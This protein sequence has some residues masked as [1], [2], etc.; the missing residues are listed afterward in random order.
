MCFCEQALLSIRG[1]LKKIAVIAVASGSLLAPSVVTQQPDRN[2]IKEF[3]KC[4]LDEHLMCVAFSP[5]DNQLAIG[6][7]KGSLWLWSI[8][9][10]EK[11]RLFMSSGGKESTGAILCVAFSPDGK[12]ILFGADNQVRLWDIGTKKE[13]FCLEGHGGPVRSVAFRGD[14]RQALSGSTS[15][16]TI[17]EWNLETGKEIRKFVGEDRPDTLS[18]APNG[19]YVIATEFMAV[20]VWDLDQGKSVNSLKGHELR[21]EGAFYSSDGKQIVSASVDHEMRV[22]DS[23]TGKVVRQFGKSRLALCSFAVSPDGRLLLCGGTNEI[24]FW[25]AKSG[26]EV[27]RVQDLEGNVRVAFSTKGDLAASAEQLGCI[28]LWEIR[29]PKK[30]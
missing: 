10:E 16:F 11:P 18:V 3:R 4:A 27:K 30:R 13:V 1:A 22:W 21:V 19:R 7:M 8:K 6:T 20:S 9:D 17:R 28:R 14:G 24:S 25:D 29:Q 15:D 5:V 26:E 2:S 12:R 23:D